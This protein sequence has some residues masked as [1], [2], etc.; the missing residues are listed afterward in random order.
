MS[1]GSGRGTNSTLPPELKTWHWGAFIFTWLWGLFNKT[2]IGLFLFVGFILLI[3]VFQWLASH[4]NL[5]QHPVWFMLAGLTLLA[6]FIT[7]HVYHGLYGNQWA[8]CNKRWNNVASFKRT[9]R[10]WSIAALV[11]V[12]VSV[13]FMASSYYFNRSDKTFAEAVSKVRAHSGIQKMIGLPME[14]DKKT[15]QISSSKSKPGYFIQ[16]RFTMQGSKNKAEVFFLAFK[17]Q[18]KWEIVR[19]A[20]FVKDHDKLFVLVNK[21]KLPK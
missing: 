2:Y 10:R 16:Y 8:W 11:L 7:I 21:K 18:G 17:H 20:A 6:Y 19:Q 3:T 5:A 1:L 15:L 9:Q 12:L 13:G 4:F 14:V